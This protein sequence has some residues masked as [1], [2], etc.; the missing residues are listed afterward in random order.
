MRPTRLSFTPAAALL[1]G[2]ATNVTGGAWTLTATSAGDGLAHFTTIQNNSATDH[3]GKTA[4]IVG[5][6]ANGNAQTEVRALPAGTSTVTGVKYFKT[7][8]S[9]TPSA[10]IGVDTMNIGYAANAV[11]PTVVMDYNFAPFNVGLGVEIT[12]TINYGL[13]HTFDAVFDPTVLYATY[14]FFDHPSIV[15]QTTSKDGNYAAPV[16]GIRL[17]VNS[18]TAGATVQAN[19]T[20]GT[21]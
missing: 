7:I 18:V 13:Q 9:V 8:T 12:G 14:V 21:R 10:T 6:D 17:I 11:S 3:S 2:Y 1:T 5:T 16:V 19:F 15:A 4:T 20:Q